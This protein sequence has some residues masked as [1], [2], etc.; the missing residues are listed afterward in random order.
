MRGFGAGDT[1]KNPC[2]ER[3]NNIVSI[4][5]HYDFF[6]NPKAFAKFQA[7]IDL[8]KFIEMSSELQAKESAN[9]M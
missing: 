4:G 6:K 2:W 8:G 3:L 5:R 1:K 9:N 7:W